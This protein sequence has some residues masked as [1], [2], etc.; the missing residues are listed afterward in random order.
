[1]AI[2]PKVF[3]LNESDAPITRPALSFSCWHGTLEKQR[4]Q[5]SAAYKIYCRLGRWSGD[6]GKP[7]GVG[8]RQ[9]EKVKRGRGNVRGLCVSPGSGPYVSCFNTPLHHLSHPTLQGKDSGTSAH[10]SELLSNCYFGT[11]SPPP[12]QPTCTVSFK[13]TRNAFIRHSCGTT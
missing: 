3:T 1:M 10:P 8:D 2:H 9:T 4:K 11:D 12:A 5:Q 7:E 6:R 13:F